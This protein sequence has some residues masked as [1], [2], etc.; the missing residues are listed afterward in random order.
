[1][2]MSSQA[3]LSIYE[4]MEII[5]DLKTLG[6]KSKSFS[7][8]ALNPPWFALCLGNEIQNL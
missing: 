2:F 7:S 4:K 1:M 6:Y 5:T 8:V 3:Y